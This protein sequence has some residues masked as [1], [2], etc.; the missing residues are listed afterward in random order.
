MKK[1]ADTKPPV[2]TD[3]HQAL[4]LSVFICGFEIWASAANLYGR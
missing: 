3:K 4:C 1:E 2:Y